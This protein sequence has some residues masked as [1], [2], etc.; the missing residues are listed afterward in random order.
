MSGIKY[1]DFKWAVKTLGLISLTTKEKAKKA[2]IKLSK[3]YH[4]DMPDGDTQKFQDI[5]KAYKII[6]EYIDNFRFHFDDKEF[7]G[8]YPFATPQKGDWMYGR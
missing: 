1:N 7:E 6:T 2:Y 3:K 5:N 4:P 8:Q